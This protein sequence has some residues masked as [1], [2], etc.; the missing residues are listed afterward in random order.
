MTK[1]SYIGSLLVSASLIVLPSCGDDTPGNSTENEGGGGSGSPTAGFT[2]VNQPSTITLSKQYETMEGFGASDCWLGEQIGKYWTD[3][4]DQIARLL[5]SQNVE[6]GQPEGIGLSMWRVNLGGGTAEQGAGS[7]IDANNRAECYLKTGSDEYDWSK[8]S[9]Q[10]YF[11]NKAKEYGCESFVLFSNTPLVRWTLNGKGYSSSGAYANLRKENFS[12]F[13]GYMADVADYF[14]KKGFN[15]SHISP[16]NEPQYNWDGHAQE[17][18]GWKNFQIA[19]LAKELDAALT[20]H[21][22]QTKILIPE[23]GAW[24][25]L[26]E[27]DKSD[28][29]G[30]IDAFFDPSSSNYLGGLSHVDKIAAGHSYWSFDNWTDMRNVRRTAAESA[31]ARGIRLWQTEWSMLDAAPSEIGMSYEQMSEFDIAIYMSKV[32]HNDLT[33]GHCTSWSYWTAMSVERYGQK[34]RFELIKTTP[35]GGEYSDDFTK[36]GKV[37]ATDNLWVLG[38]YSLFV[39]PGYKRI[40]VYCRD[41]KNFFGTAYASPD[42]KT[43]VAVYTNCDKTRGAQ[44]DAAFVDCGTLKSVK[45]Y[46]TTGGKHLKAD[47]FD[48]NDKAFCDPYS[49][50]TFVYTFE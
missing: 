24:S 33:V 4:R 30:Q 29:F 17:G 15:I 16:V 11:M 46:T 8:C 28:R 1:L 23:A 20:A 50:T 3:N 49:V 43:I 18:S 42:G 21:G 10:Q 35:S 47:S 40:D 12:D 37:K 38:N 44:I 41:T 13:A 19:N 25:F 7:D 9:G 14:N 22:S 5:F 32:I 48:V 36:G 45:R 34:N 27:G 6:N 2:L 39:R 31:S 26:Y